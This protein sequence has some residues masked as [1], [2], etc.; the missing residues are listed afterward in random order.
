MRRK[1]KI[2]LGSAAVLAV[3]LFLAARLFSAVMDG[4]WAAQRSAVSEAYTKTILAKVKKVDRFVGDKSYQVIQGE[5][6][7]GQPLIVWVDGENIHT[8]MAADG[9]SSE[10]AEENVKA[11]RPVAEIL[12]T[13]PG[14]MNGQPVWE[15]F[16][17][18]R[19]EQDKRDHYF[20]DYYTFKDGALIDTWRL[21]IQ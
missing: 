20:Y 19:S 15:V 6:K 4:E 16:Y 12:R 3:L 5:D 17:K 13:V 18:L 8:E 21:T 10:K 9:I 1:W 11:K 14:M 7:I 2:I